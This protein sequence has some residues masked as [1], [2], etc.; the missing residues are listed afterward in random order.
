[1]TVGFKIS[2]RLARAF[3]LIA[4]AAALS[5]CAVR[6][7]TQPGS[8]PSVHTIIVS[9]DTAT[10]A[11]SGTLR[12]L[13]ELRDSSGALVQ[14]RLINW[15]SELANIASVSADGM[16]EGKDTGSTSIVATS[17]GHSASARVKVNPHG[18]PPPVPTGFFVSPTGTSTSTGTI[19]RPL[20]L[21]TALTNASGRIH[22]GDTV[23]LRGGTYHGNFRS[24][25]TGTASK[26]IVVRQY[27]G[28]R[29]I[30]DGGGVSTTP[31]TWAVYGQYSVFWGFEFTN[32]DP[33][34]VLADTER[35]ANVIANYANH[36]KYVNL[37]LHDGGV[38][39]YNES[40]YYDVEIV[41]CVIY[42]VGYQ[43]TDRGHSHAIYIRSNTGPV[44]AR[45][46]IMFSGFGYGVHVFTNP[47]EGELNNVRIEG[48]IA[49]NMGTLSTNSNSDNIL[50]GGDAY[51]TGGV[52]KSNYTY[53]SP[54]VTAKNVQVGYGATLNGSVQVL[55]NYF[56]GGGTVLDVGYWSSLTASN[57]Q[58]M[59]TAS[60]VT[61]NDA[62]IQMSTFAGQMQ[63]SLPTA[64][65]VV[66]RANPYETGRANVAVY[67]WGQE[68]S[69][70]L[71]L[72]GIVPQ[73]ASYEIRNVQDLFGSPVVSGTYSGG[74]VTLP[75][76]GVT[77]P[78]P[79]GFSSSRSP[80]TGTTFNA[81]VV[82]LRR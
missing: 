81:Y 46:N 61:L 28:E 29:A 68:S 14:N 3:L 71:D 44:T 10:I 2:H 78:V 17:E 31:S 33:N 74:S 11:V 22:P 76:R 16:V 73:G 20:D 66:L 52:V 32:S 8:S 72:S 26:P 9:P 27:P 50:F 80:A 13:V 82:A 67:N 70:S 38:A 60:L 36:T 41:G 15:R 79:V 47:G 54:G 48:N 40:P 49:F 23:W 75:I 34:R 12:L 59:G 65:K 30:I 5:A 42:N 51:S 35:R 58:L 1:M 77:P 24:Q 45:D 37:V 56:A 43:R 64:T 55:D 39:F 69:V 63:A 21:P 25:L 4:A 57:N 53:E 6:D 7:T 19:D 62:S 18:P